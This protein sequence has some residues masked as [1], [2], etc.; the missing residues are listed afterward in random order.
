MNSTM[1]EQPGNHMG[2]RARARRWR[3][4]LLWVGAL[5]ALALAGWIATFGTYPMTD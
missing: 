4:T 2:R 5:A 3:T 1:D